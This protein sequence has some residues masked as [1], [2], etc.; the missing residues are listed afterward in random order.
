ME[1]IRRIA[2]AP[3]SDSLVQRLEAREAVNVDLGVLKDVLDEFANE[4]RWGEEWLDAE[5]DSPASRKEGGC[6]EL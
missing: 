6:R 2:P 1:R 3:S 4:H 5:R